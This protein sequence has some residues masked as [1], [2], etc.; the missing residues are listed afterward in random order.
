MDISHKTVLQHHL[1]Q[2]SLAQS[3]SLPGS[4]LEENN[5][6]IMAAWNG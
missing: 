3:R 2:T 6:Y 4:W 5:Q 1:P